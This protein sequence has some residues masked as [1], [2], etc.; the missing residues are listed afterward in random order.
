MTTSISV[1][2]WSVSNRR[3]KSPAVVGSGSARAH[4]VEERSVV[5]AHL[6]VVENRP[7]AQD[8][9]GD[10]QDVVGPAVRAALHQDRQPRIELPNEADLTRELVDGAEPAA[11]IA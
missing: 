11:G 2:I 3:Q 1:S 4:R 7:A 5:A 8:V 9:E 6:D 10:V